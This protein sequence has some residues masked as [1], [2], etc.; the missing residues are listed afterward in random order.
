MKWCDYNCEEAA[1]PDEALEGACRVPVRA[2][3]RIASLRQN[4]LSTRPL[5]APKSVPPDVDEDASEPAAQRVGISQPAEPR[6]T[7]EQG[8]LHDVLDVVWSIAEATG[9]TQ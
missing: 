9:Q 5:G 6:Q 3:G 8:L 1:F 7:A 2:G 4:A